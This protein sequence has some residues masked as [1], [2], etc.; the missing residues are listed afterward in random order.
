MAIGDNTRRTGG[1]PK[2]S[3]YTPG[4]T[5][6]PAGIGQ[7]VA[8]ATTGGPIGTAGGDLAG[9]YPNPSVA[10]LQGQ[11]AQVELALPQHVHA[12]NTFDARLT[13]MAQQISR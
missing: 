12:I 13:A 8:A 1:G 6:P 2:A 7:A 9:T 10:Q 5:M 4:G 3:V 11:N